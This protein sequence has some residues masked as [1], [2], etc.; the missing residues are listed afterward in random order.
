MGPDPGRRLP[1]PLWLKRGTTITALLLPVVLILIFFIPSLFSGP[2]PGG[3]TPGSTADE[4]APRPATAFSVS[5]GGAA[6]RLKELPEDERDE[7]LRDWARTALAARLGLSAAAWQAESY[8]TSPLREQGLTDL[9]AQP[10]GP[11][12]ALYDARTGTLHLL[13]APD[14]HASRTIGGLLDQYRTD[15][16]SDPRTVQVHDYRI[17]PDLQAIQIA[18]G[19]PQPAAEVRAANGY[20]TARVDTA[21]G[22]RGFLNRTRHLSRLRV[23]GDQLWADGW[24]WPNDPAPAFTEADVAT[25]Q[26]A[27][28]DG[29]VRPAFSLDRLQN[30]TAADLRA[31]LPGVPARTI[32]ALASHDWG[33]L[34][35]GSAG[36]FGGVLV[37]ALATG[38]ESPRLSRAGLQLDRTRLFALFQL[39]STGGKAA[40]EHA[41]YDGPLKGTSVGM[42]L[43]Y[44]D[45]MAKSWSVGTGKALPN[46]LLKGIPTY[47]GTP[48]PPGYCADIAKSES[49][50]LWF[51]Q[52]TT[53]FSY[54][55]N[56]LDIGARA[57]Q[58]FMKSQSGAGGD[59]DY[60]AARG[61]DW[62]ERHFQEIADFEPQYAR[63][64]QIMRWS[65]AMD[66]LRTHADAPRLAAPDGDADSGLRFDSWFKDHKE[67]R[68]RSTPSFVDAPSAKTEVFLTEPA[69]P[70]KTCGYPSVTGGV[71][72]ADLAE[73]QPGRQ[74]PPGAVPEGERRGGLYDPASRVD[75]VTG[76]GHLKQEWLDDQGV[77]IRTVERRL[78]HTSDGTVIAESSS[79]AG[80]NLS[81]GGLKIRAPRSAPHTM[82]IERQVSKGVITESV[83]LQ[84][85][86]VGRLRT[87]AT[88][89]GVFVSWVSGTLDRVRR[90]MG[91]AQDRLERRR[92]GVPAR[93][94]ALVG[95]RDASG[96]IVFK[97]GD[98]TAAAQITPDAP[99][100]DQGV[101]FQLGAPGPNGT[102]RQMFGVQRQS[103][104]PGKGPGSPRGPP[105]GDWMEFVAD[106]SDGPV[107]A[108]F[109]VPGK[110]A[111]RT[112]VEM[113]GGTSFDVRSLGDRRWAS[114]WVF[115][116]SVVAAAVVRDFPLL[117]RAQ[118]DARDSG[119]GDFRGVP[120]G[121]DATDGAALVSANRMIAAPPGTQIAVRVQEAIG[122]HPSAPPQMRLIDGRAVNHEL[123][124]FAP[125]GKRETISLGQAVNRNALASERNRDLTDE[126]GRPFHN[127][128]HSSQQVEVVPGSIELPAS[129]NPW[130]PPDLVTLTNQPQGPSL[131]QIGG[132]GWGNPP[133]VGPPPPPVNSPPRRG[134]PSPSPTGR[135]TAPGRSVWVP[136]LIVCSDDAPHIEGCPN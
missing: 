5:Y 86:D 67:L 22:L 91:S 79:E 124:T 107:V 130:I 132:P 26:H 17:R 131:V 73:K 39:A 33:A 133:G 41:R 69:K 64:E 74:L 98:G 112:R 24:K 21:D 106:G 45:L 46:D 40:F 104:P 125:N 42:T 97:T 103:Q 115:S 63:L 28:A 114:R 117:Q 6:G 44:T 54:A 35:F 128:R 78:S 94:A 121:P 70:F 48:I 1:P 102:V 38:Q 92:D 81:F 71:G 37:Q 111:Q 123:G 77:P 34:G 105:P 14:G 101:V 49:W 13:V 43:E 116:Q 100:S 53:G 75:H 8:D 25:L 62:W 31:A 89:G 129:V 76:D 55:R 4:P 32:R 72:L 52:N 58:L 2:G 68:E 50:R 135:P 3:A 30:P 126:R 120:L 10:T 118:H 56:E 99:G 84:G 16:G 90:I 85:Q 47:A 134:S 60:P 9:A 110:T 80:R 57:T 95:F 88:P 12:R 109:G 127:P 18:G 20:V 7:Q 83:R 108:H 119:D 19:T 59:P 93:A 122:P 11:G 87:S 65:G 82:R 23:K 15:H 61:L 113:P 51:A 29:G 136:V 36:E 96:R 27:Y 66:W